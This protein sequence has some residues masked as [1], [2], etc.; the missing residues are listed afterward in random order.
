MKRLIAFLI[1][2]SVMVIS[3]V[4][5]GETK[6]TCFG[7][8]WKVASI[9]KVELEPDLDQ[10]TID[11]LK[12]RYN[13][14]D[15][16]GIVA[17]ARESFVSEAVFASFYLKFSNNSAYTHDPVM[18]REATWVFYKLTENTG[19]ISFYTEL[20]ASNGNPYP[21]I[22]PDL[23]YNA[24]ANTMLITVNYVGFMVTLKLTR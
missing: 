17:N 19:F 2:V 11:A 6:P 7:G 24:E 22:C 10:S 12:E 3:L 20:D 21:V 23:V 13:A 9:E 15:E 16:A 1:L 4:G 5:C 18:D 14:E 8:E